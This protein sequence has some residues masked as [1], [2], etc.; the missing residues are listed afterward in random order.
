MHGISGIIEKYEIH[1]RKYGIS[2]EKFKM[3]KK[4]TQSNIPR[5]N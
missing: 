5:E 3:I 4:F 2:S 1:P